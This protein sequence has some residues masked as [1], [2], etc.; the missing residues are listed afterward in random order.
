MATKPIIE[1]AADDQKPTLIACMAFLTLSLVRTRY[2]PKMELK[3][4]IARTS[5]GN[6]TPL[7]P[8]DAQPRIIAET[9]VPSYDSKMSA[10]IPAQSPTLSPTLS[11]IVAAFLG[12]SSGIFFSIFPTR[13]APTSAALV[14]IPPPTLMNKAM[15]VPPKPKPSNTSYACSPYIMNMTVPPNSPGP[16]V[17]HPGAVAVADLILQA[18]PKLCLGAAGWWG[19]TVIFMIYGEQAYE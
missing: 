8:N 6:M 12:S 18:F 7:C 14:K 13:S 19:G 1:T 16:F 17:A 10:A 9:I 4:P 2:V 3:T 5:S 15:S 11:A